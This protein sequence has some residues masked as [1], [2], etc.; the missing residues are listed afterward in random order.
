MTPMKHWMQK[1]G[2]FPRESY[3][4]WEDGCRTL[5]SLTELRELWIEMNV[6]DEFQYYDPSDGTVEEQAL[7]FILNAL[8]PVHSQTFQIGLNF[9]LP[10]PV[11]LAL[12]DVPFEL[13]CHGKSYDRKTFPL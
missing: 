1:R 5:A 13:L 11:V 9:E 3:L 7:L 4:D 6:W 8:K 2:S 12:G 10:S